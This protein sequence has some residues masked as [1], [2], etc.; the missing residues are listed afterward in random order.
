MK[1][2]KCELCGNNQ[3]VKQGDY[4]VCQ[5]CG[6][7]YA[8]EAAKKLIVDIASP[9]SIDGAVEVT[10]GEAEKTKFLNDLNTLLELDQIAEFR[11]KL[12]IAI[13]DYP[14][15]WKVWFLSFKSYL[16]FSQNSY[17]RCMDGSTIRV[18]PY[19]IFFEKASAA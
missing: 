18:L 19:R 9:V 8:P 2:I 16:L 3:L 14:G 15:E 10:K 11:K 12:E 6:T 5:F 7:K 4:F 1:V 17:L 13:R